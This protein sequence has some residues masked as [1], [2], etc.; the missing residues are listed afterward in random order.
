MIPPP[1]ELTGSY[2]VPG[3]RFFEQVST[4]LSGADRVDSPS[5]L[6]SPLSHLTTI[7]R[8]LKI[9]EMAAEFQDSHKKVWANGMC[10]AA[11]R[12]QKLPNTNSSQPPN[13]STLLF[14]NSARL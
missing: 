4:P 5:L 2:K 13:K 1:K 9:K 14:V 7:R 8:V 6:L 3:P 11:V 12:V 10:V